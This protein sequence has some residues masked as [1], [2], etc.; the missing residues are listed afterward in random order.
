MKRATFFGLGVTTLSYA[1]VASAGYFAFGNGAP[2]NILTG[3]G[4]YNPYWLLDLANVA[5]V[6]HLV[7][8]DQVNI[9]P[10]QME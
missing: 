8:A 5:V 9:L 10:S 4:F 6:V 2:A 1:S 3:F 7:G